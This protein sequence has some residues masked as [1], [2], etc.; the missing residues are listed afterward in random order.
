MF[1]GTVTGEGTWT[2]IIRNSKYDNR[3]SPRVEYKKYSIDECAKTVQVLYNSGKI[4]FPVGFEK[5]KMGEL[6]LEQ[7]YRFK[8]KRWTKR[9]QKDDA[10][11]A[12]IGAIMLAVEK[13]RARIPSIQLRI[14]R[15]GC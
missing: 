10:P 5:T 2:N 12:L 1:D 7:M 9:G 14:S 8:G 6:F 13:K 3:L 15:N 11:D 4:K